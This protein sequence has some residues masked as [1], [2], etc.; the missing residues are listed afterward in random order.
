M[1]NHNHSKFTFLFQRQWNSLL[2]SFIIFPLVSDFLNK[3]IFFVSITFPIWT[4]ASP[5]VAYCPP[6]RLWWPNCNIACASVPC[7]LNLLMCEPV[8]HVKHSYFHVN[9]FHDILYF[10]TTLS[11]KIERVPKYSFCIHHGFQGNWC[12]GTSVY[13]LPVLEYWL[14]TVQLISTNSY[15]RSHLGFDSLKLQGLMV[16]HIEGECQLWNYMSSVSFLVLK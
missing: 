16:Y 11:M 14:G 1:C 8:K 4:A 3:T 9:K 5:P 2:L 6:S 10:C 7:I 13:K 12:E 15:T